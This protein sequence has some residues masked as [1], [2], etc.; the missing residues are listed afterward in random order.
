MAFEQL[1]NSIQP[2][3]H[4]E[5]MQPQMSPVAQQLQASPP[6]PPQV[7]PVPLL[8]QKRKRGNMAIGLVASIQKLYAMKQAANAPAP[9]PQQKSNLMLE[10]GWGGKGR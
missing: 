4:E 9:A 3:A 8:E 2:M 5:Q 10:G 7:D 6:L 1:N